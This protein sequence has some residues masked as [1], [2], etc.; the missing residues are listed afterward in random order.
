[1][2]CS[3]C[4]HRWTVDLDWIERWDQGKERCPACG[5]DCTKEDAP[6]VTVDPNDPAL[7][8]ENVPRFSWYHTSTHADW[9]PV[10]IDPEAGLTP[11]T[12]LMM[13]GDAR[14]AAWADRQ[15]AKA[16]HVG[17][18]EAAIHN[19]LRRLDDQGDD[20]K[21]FYLYRVHLRPDIVVRESWLID[22]SNFVGDVEL[23]EVCP[24]GTDVAR[25]LNYHEDPGGISLALGRDAITAT[26]QVPVPALSSLDDDVITSTANDIRAATEIPPRPSWMRTTRVT[27]TRQ[28]HRARQ[29]AEE[30]SDALPVNLRDQFRS[31]LGYRI[32]TDPEQWARYA[33]G[34]ATTIGAPDRLLT[35]LARHA[36]RHL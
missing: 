29:I 12:R 27:L 23:A 34:L 13:G 17:T 32:D 8:D 4:G 36:I 33:L 10:A 14:V 31:A 7:I 6:R 30:L 20:G 26:Q 28:M 16:L 2:L 35:A 18:Y 3:R 9:P 24:P 21:Q 1:M 19:M 5:V 15:R 11:Q 22:P 25:Y